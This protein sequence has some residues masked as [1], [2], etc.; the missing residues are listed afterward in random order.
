MPSIPLI[1]PV[2]M[3]CAT[4]TVPEVN[5]GAYSTVAKQEIIGCTPCNPTVKECQVPAEFEA[6]VRRAV[7]EAV[8][9]KLPKAAPPAKAKKP[10]KRNT[11]RR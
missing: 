1:V 3:I 2:M 9:P 10:T 6:M 7:T 4:V 5:D 8:G 11:K